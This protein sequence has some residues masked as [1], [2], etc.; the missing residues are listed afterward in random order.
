MLCHV[1]CKFTDV[2]EGHTA[3]VFSVEE[4]FFCPE[5]GGCMFLQNIGEFLPNYHGSPCHEAGNVNRLTP[6]K[7]KMPVAH[8]MNNKMMMR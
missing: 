8:T 3:F 5:A 6:Q 4:S 7:F 1:A 2:L